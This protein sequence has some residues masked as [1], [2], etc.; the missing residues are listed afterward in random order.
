[1]VGELFKSLDP[2][3]VF[4]EKDNLTEAIDQF[5]EDYKVDMMLVIPKKYGWLESLFRTSHTTRLAFHTHLPL[6]CM[7]A[8]G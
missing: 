7:R 1:V 3:F 5:I 6:L 8:I 2:E 4:E